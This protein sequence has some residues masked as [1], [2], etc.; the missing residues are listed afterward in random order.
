MWPEGPFVRCSRTVPRFYFHT[1]HPSEQDEQDD[2]G[3]DF[4]SVHAAKGEAVRYAGELL[5]DVGEHFWDKGDFELT[6]T[7]DQG[8]VLFAM[9]M[10]GIEAPAIRSERH[11]N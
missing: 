8:L 3:F 11:E 1:N 5:C 7:D 9:R 6:V 2:E 4:S 10:I